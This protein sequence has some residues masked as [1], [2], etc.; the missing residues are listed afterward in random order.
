MLLAIDTATRLASLALYD[1]QGVHAETMWRSR[2]NHTV[3]LMT[4]ITR[5][6]ELA[7]ASKDTLTAIGVALGPGSFTDLRVGM[8]VAKGLA[9]ARG[10]PI[11]A[12]PT[13]DIIAHAHAY[14]SLPMWV[15]LAAGR[16]RYSVARYASKRGA[17]KRVSDYALVD[18]AGLADLIMREMEA[19]SKT[20][21]AFICGDVDAT[22]AR[23]L[24]EQCGAR[25]VL[26]SPAHNARRAAFLA[27]LAWARFQRGESDDPHSL[28]PMYLPHESVEGPRPSQSPSAND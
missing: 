6:L 5:L 10:I 12:I 23:T 26:A 8:S 28:A 25:V 2:E 20:A 24:I 9:Y 19:E 17:I 4:Q 7:R 1:A 3:E 11:V 13:L 16:G 21:R 18:A 27:E 15:V 22:L 14:Q